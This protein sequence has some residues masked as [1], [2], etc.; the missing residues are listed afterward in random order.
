MITKQD[1]KL[2]IIFQVRL[3]KKIFKVTIIK[4]K[5]SQKEIYK[6]TSKRNI[7]QDLSFIKYLCKVVGALGFSFIT[8]FMYQNHQKLFCFKSFKIG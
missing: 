6:K 2:I 7:F 5:L 3:S 1:L 8:L 4:T